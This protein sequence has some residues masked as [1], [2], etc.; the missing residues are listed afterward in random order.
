MVG[1]E[2]KIKKIIS[3]V[4]TT[5]DVSLRCAC[6]FN[7]SARA[8]LKDYCCKFRLHFKQ[9]QS[10]ERSGVKYFGF[11]SNEAQPIRRFFFFSF[12]I[13]KLLKQGLQ[14]PVQTV[15]SSS[16]YCVMCH[17]S[18][19]MAVNACALKC[20]GEYLSLD[21]RL[22]TEVNHHLR[23]ARWQRSKLRFPLSVIIRHGFLNGNSRQTST[24]LIL[25][26]EKKEKKQKRHRKFPI[27]WCDL[28][29]YLAYF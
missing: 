20:V 16:V 22:T 17:S 7:Q 9:A 8:S 23:H 10:A 3:L 4:P 11:R 26:M 29:V 24:N 18:I 13:L 1:K 19:V 6:V 14:D 2:G 15:A 27:D 5:A 12:L 21:S 28:R 25:V